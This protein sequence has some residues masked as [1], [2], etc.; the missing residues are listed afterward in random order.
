M[1]GLSPGRRLGPYELESALGA[2]G[3]GEVYAAHD[4]RLGRRVALKVSQ[5]RFGVRFEREARAIAALNHPHICTL[6]DVG[7]D[8]LVMELVEGE[9]LRDVLKRGALPIEQAVAYGVQIADALTAAHAHGVIHRDLKPANVMVAESGVKV[10]DFGLA[11]RVEAVSEEAATASSPLPEA[12]TQAGQVMGTVAYM[13]PE[14]AEGR[15]VDARSDIFSLGVVL[16]EMLCGC[17]PFRGETALA[18]LAS[19]LRGAPERPSLMRKG[20]PHELERIVL[21]CL[22][23]QPEA[24]YATAAELRG[25]L[26]GIRRSARASVAIPSAALLGTGLLVLLGAL[27]LGWRSWQHRERA[28]W[29]EQEAVPEIA[30]LI[31]ED[32]RLAALDLFRE[33]ERYAPASRSLYKLAEGVATRPIRFETTPAGARVYVSDY[34]AAAGDDLSGW[35]LLGVSPLSVE[36][37]PAWGYYRVRASKEGFATADHVFG[38]EAVVRLELQPESSVPPG[39]VRVPATPATS[40]APSIALPA[41]WIDRYEVT[42]RQYKRF[43]DAGGYRKPEYWRYRFVKEGRTLSWHQ[44]MAELHD[45]TGRPGPATWELGAYPDGKDEKP[46]AGVSWYEAAAYAEFVGKALPTVYEWNEAAARDYNSNILKLSSFGKG[47]ASAGAHRGMSRFGTYDMAGN[48]KEWVFNAAADRRY[49]LGGAWNEAPYTYYNL[50]TQPPFARDAALG[51]RC[52]LRVEPAPETS[53]APLPPP[54]PP[55]PRGEAVSDETF[56]T[57][58]DL[59]A[60]EKTELEARVERTD[61]SSPIFRRETVSFRAAYGDERVIAHVFLPRSATPPYQV[62][63]VMGG[64]TIMNVVQRVEDFDYPF[65][66]IVRSGRAVVIPAYSGTLERGP[67]PPSLP[68][69]QELE[70]AIHWSMDLG[71][72][73]DYLQTRPDIDIQK[74][75]FY[76]VSLGATEGVR[77][78]AVDSRFKVAVL[79]SGGLP[80]RRAPQI[81][82]WNYAPRVHIPVLMVNGR[83]DSI[84]PLETSQRPLFEA[85]GTRQKQHILYD[86]GHRNLVTRPDLI[87]EV[88][89]WLDRYLGPVTPAGA[90]R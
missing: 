60:Y 80:S 2:G 47:L 81:D 85:L 51:F 40:T 20:I 8:Y 50:D 30:R 22:E 61:D 25:A 53:F 38:G 10:L 6:Y 13:S 82:P 52:A 56:R 43:V 12:V 64:I 63:A 58:L 70:R 48:V 18:V 21:R 23:K 71:R 62:V 28:R 41:F 19:T 16:Y 17:R 45:L 55:A 59:H 78:T 42:N 39:M 14:Q 76:G 88:L 1:E 57:F 5:R 65:E 89:N 46:V 90:A 87:G 11:K 73:L 67:S 24:R 86:G 49:A 36:D 31:Q 44:A 68:A 54:P 75:G 77:L 37:V 74:L 66:F 4:T 35:Q 79:S 15:R 26:A 9:S 7:P 72:T 29:V 84:F 83:D 27:G 34:T 69:N 33:A 3:M 32:R